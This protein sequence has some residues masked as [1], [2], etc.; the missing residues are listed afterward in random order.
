MSLP[1]LELEQRFA[2]HCSCFQLEMPAILSHSGPKPL[3]SSPGPSLQVVH[4]GLV[5]A[6]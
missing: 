2:E 6:L 1:W 3:G 4:S 5:Q